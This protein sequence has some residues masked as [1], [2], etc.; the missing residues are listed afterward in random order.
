MHLLNYISH[1]S[2]SVLTN[3]PTLIYLFI[4]SHLIS[5][6]LLNLI[7]YLLFSHFAPPVFSSHLLSNPIFLNITNLPNWYAC[8]GFKTVSSTSAATNTP[9]ARAVCS[10]SINLIRATV[11]VSVKEWEWCNGFINRNFVSVKY[12]KR[13]GI[14]EI[15][16]EN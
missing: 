14:E 10:P 7:T 5:S 1:F 6:L 11:A 2:I 3:Y 15:E 13:N 16:R 9:N 8:A 12:R 4:S